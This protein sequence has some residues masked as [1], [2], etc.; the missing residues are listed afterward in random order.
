MQAVDNWVEFNQEKCWLEMETRLRIS[1]KPEFE[2]LAQFS[3]CPHFLFH[4]IEPKETESVRIQQVSPK[5]LSTLSNQKG[6]PSIPK[7]G[8]TRIL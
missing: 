2:P 1:R 4:P 8:S 5:S 3:S 6:N 7:T